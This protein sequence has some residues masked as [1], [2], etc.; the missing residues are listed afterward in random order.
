MFQPSYDDGLAR[1]AVASSEFG[2][3]GTEPGFQFFAGSAALIDMLHGLSSSA[4]D[5]AD[6]GGAGPGHREPIA[7]RRVRMR[8]R[9]RT[10]PRATESAGVAVVRCGVGAV[11]DQRPQAQRP[12]KHW[13][14]RVSNRRHDV[15]RLA[16]ERRRSD[17]PRQ[18]ATKRLC[19][20]R[21]RCRLKYRSGGKRS[22]DRAENLHQ[23]PSSG[24]P[25]R[26]P[27]SHGCPVSCSATACTPPR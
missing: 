14:R 20:R 15:G 25:C 23:I 5:A 24:W 8:G 16:Q 12:P 13:H 17:V 19:I 1:T 7:R 27:I 10:D 22:L 21:R 11:Q 3:A 6:P 2:S 4:C 26:R 18:T 9:R